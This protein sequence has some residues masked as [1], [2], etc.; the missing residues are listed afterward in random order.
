MGETRRQFICAGIATATLLSAGVSVVAPTNDVP[1]LLAFIVGTP[2]E[3]NWECVHAAS[4]SEALLQY[5]SDNCGLN[6]CADSGGADECE[7]EFCE[8]MRNYDV[9]RVKQFDGV[10][11]PARADWIRAGLGS[12]C[13]RCDYETDNSSCEIIDGCVVCHECMKY[14]DWLIADPE[15]AEEMRS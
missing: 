4:E 8:A 5:V 2:G 13:E 10:E 9:D 7:C 6:S 15:R 3:S 12:L 11:A 14:E 1:K